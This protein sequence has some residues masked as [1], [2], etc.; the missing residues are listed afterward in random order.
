MVSGTAHHLSHTTGCHILVSLCLTVAA[1]ASPT[2]GSGVPHSNSQTQKSDSCTGTTWFAYAR[3]GNVKNIGECLDDALVQGGTSPFTSILEQHDEA[4]CTALVIASLNGHIDAV[5]YLHSRGADISAP[6][7]SGTNALMHAASQGHLNVIKYLQTEGI[8]VHATTTGTTGDTALTFAARNGRFPA[9]KYLH[10]LDLVSDHSDMDHA[11]TGADGAVRW[12]AAQGS[13]EALTRL[14][15]PL[16]IA[17]EHGDSNS[18][19]DAVAAITTPDSHGFTAAFW[20][21]QK[22]NLKALMYLEDA[23]T[24]LGTASGTQNITVLHATSPGKLTL[25]MAAAYFGHTEVS[26]YLIERGLSVDVED[27]AGWTAIMWAVLGG[28]LSVVR[29]LEHA[30]ASVRQKEGHWDPLMVA[31]ANGYQDIVEWFLARGLSYE[32]KDKGGRTAEDM[33]HTHGHTNV[34]NILGNIKAINSWHDA[35]TKQGVKDA[36][37]RQQAL[38]TEARNLARRE[39]RGADIDDVSLERSVRAHLAALKARDSERERIVQLRER[40]RKERVLAEQRMGQQQ[41]LKHRHTEL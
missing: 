39:A 38:E 40:Q 32:A 21:A 41:F 18:V 2:S 20:A 34:A 26:V 27:S 36:D 12:A 33:A 35:Q 1:S 13:D 8:D 29:A 37:A 7:W 9:M 17:A 11:W 14:V 31:A 10:K 4:G 30:R 16:L 25:L 3:T 24:R 6:C 5:Q 15:E 28:K 19:A 23:A 22:G